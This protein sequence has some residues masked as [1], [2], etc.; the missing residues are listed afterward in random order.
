MTL[1]RVALVSHSTPTPSTCTLSSQNSMWAASLS[2]RYCAPSSHPL[3]QDYLVGI[4]GEMFM[5]PISQSF[6]KSSKIVVVIFA[7]FQ[8]DLI[9]LGSESYLLKYSLKNLDQEAKKNQHMVCGS[10]LLKFYSKSQVSYLIAC[11]TR[12]TTSS[13][14]HFQNPFSILQYHNKNL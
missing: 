14:L 5:I 2:P 8:N 13:L 7:S 10:I 4:Q 6:V 1:W 3:L 9:K 12:N 11:G